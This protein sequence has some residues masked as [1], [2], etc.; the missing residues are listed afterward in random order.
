MNNLERKFKDGSNE[1]AKLES[2]IKS[3]R[4]ARKLTQTSNSVQDGI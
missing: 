1:I 4:D 2:L 3:V